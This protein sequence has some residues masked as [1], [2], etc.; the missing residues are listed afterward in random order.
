MHHIISA[1]LLAVLLL[2]AHPAYSQ[3]TD[4]VRLVNG[5]SSHE[6]RVEVFANGAWGTVCDDEFD[7][8]EANVICRMLG[9]S[10]ALKAFGGAYY[11]RGK[12]KILMDQLECAGDEKDIFD[13]PMNASV[14]E[15][16]CNHR[17]DAGVECISFQLDDPSPVSLQVRLTCPYNMSCNNKA[18]KRGPDAGECEPSMHVE[19]IVQ[20][21]YNNTWWYISADGWDN[22]DVNVVCGQL[23]YPLAFGTVSNVNRLLPSG[24]RVPK[25]IKRQFNAKLKTVLMKDVLCEGG[26]GKLEQC[27]HH[28]F[29]SLRNSRRNKVATARCG[30]RQHPSCNKECQQQVSMLYKPSIQLVYKVYLELGKRGHFIEFF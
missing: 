19:G 3:D 4:L 27:A 11:G 24:T 21:Y 23:G 30:F 26:E 1:M 13:C 12:G 6:G 18:R 28:E 16:D 9:Y 29:G 15:H 10:G 20:V 7:I 22:A 5:P 14:G 2:A 17:E 25:R 8:N